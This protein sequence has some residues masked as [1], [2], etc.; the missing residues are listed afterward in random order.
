MKRFL[1][2]LPALLLAGMIVACSGGE[3]EPEPGPTPTPTPTPVPTPGENVPDPEGTVKVTLRNEQSGG[4]YLDNIHIDKG[5]N[6]VGGYFVSYGKV[7]GLG[8]VASI[9]KVGYADAISVTPGEGYVAYCGNY[10]GGSFYRMYVTGYTLNTS[11]EIIGAQV[12]YQKPFLGVDEALVPDLPSITVGGEGGHAEVRFTN[13]TII[14]FTVESDQEWCIAQS[15]ST[16][17][18]YFLTDA[19]AIDVNGTISTETATAKVTVTTGHGKKTVITVTRAGREPY[20]SLDRTSLTISQR[21]VSQNVGLSTNADLSALTAVA[22]MPWCH[23]EIVD[24]AAANRKA[25]LAPLRF[26]GDKMVTASRAYDP[27]VRAYVL[28][29]SADENI[30]PEERRAEISVKTQGG[31]S[32]Q[33]RASQNRGDI[34]FDSSAGLEDYPVAVSCQ[35]GTTSIRMEYCQQGYNESSLVVPSQLEITSDA[36]WL[37]AEEVIEGNWRSVELKYVSNPSEP[38]TARV[39]V[40]AKGSTTLKRDIVVT[41]NKPTVSL[42]GLKTSVPNTGYTGSFSLSGDFDSSLNFEATSDADWVQIEKK[43]AISW[44]VTYLANPTDKERKATVTVKATTGMLSVSGE[45]VQA[46]GT[47]VI[48]GISEDFAV[49]YNRISH[50]LTFNVSTSLDTKAECSADWLT[51]YLSGDKRALNVILDEA[52]VNREA[53]IT[54]TNC[55][56]KITIRQSRYADGDTF[57]EDGLQ[58]IVDFNKKLIYQLVSE[59]K[60]AWSTHTVTGATS[61]DNGE[62]NTAI[63][64]SIPNWRETFPVFNAV[65][66][67]NTNGITGWYV[68]AANEASA[69]LPVDDYWT[70]TE[71]DDEHACRRRIGKWSSNCDSCL[72]V[73]GSAAVGVHKV[74][75][76]KIR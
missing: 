57:D 58:G 30:E 5:D 35:E 16:L 61:Y 13:S 75:L 53:V 39:T 73:N 20:V 63:I 49:E 65:D 46:A 71:I 18:N 8:N 52:S 59:E 34:I 76:F 3:D 33:V 48:E 56:R 17:S 40:K 38:R 22:D 7:H 1:R 69:F 15:A 45:V 12:K 36:D 28:K 11:Q 6:F 42:A 67:L 31:G 68:P 19:V 32:M 44:N 29:I 41:Q 14:P 9:P 26:I 37:T 24:Q 55:D 21:G 43:S 70:S 23:A 2:V 60:Y 54:F 10:W 51:V 74:D 50:V 47:L 27:N 66:Q 25:E 62:A 4:N 64:H 72:K